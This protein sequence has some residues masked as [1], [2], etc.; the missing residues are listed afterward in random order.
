MSGVQYIKSSI[1]VHISL[2][3]KKEVRNHLLATFLKSTIVNK[4]FNATFLLS[5][6]IHVPRRS[7]EAHPT[8][9]PAIVVWIYVDRGQIVTGFRR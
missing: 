9:L 6:L 7:N 4:R 8:I 5:H 2:S 3:V 1:S